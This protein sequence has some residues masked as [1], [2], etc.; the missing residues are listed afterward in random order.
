MNAKIIILPQK[1]SHGQHFENEKVDVVDS[2]KKVSILVAPFLSCQLY[3]CYYFVD[4]ISKAGR[5]RFNMKINEN[6]TYAKQHFDI[7]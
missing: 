4:R 6:R 5:K 7:V 1:V 3:I 2:L